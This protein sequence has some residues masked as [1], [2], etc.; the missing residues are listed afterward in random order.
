MFDRRIRTF[1]A[2]G[3]EGITLEGNPLPIGRVEWSPDGQRIAFCSDDYFLRLWNTT[4]QSPGNPFVEG[5]LKHGKTSISWSPD[6]RT[7]ATA[8]SAHDSKLCLWN[9][10]GTTA[11]ILKGHRGVIYQLAWDPRDG[12]LA[13]VG[14]DGTIRVWSAQGQLNGTLHSGESLASVAWKPDGTQLASGCEN[15]TIQLWHPEGR[16]GRLLRGH[17]DCVTCISWSTDGR[18]IAS[19]SRDNTVRLW[20]D[21]GE[22]LFTFHGHASEVQTVGWRPHSHQILSAGR[23]GTVRLWN[24]ETHRLEWMLLLVRDKQTV[25]LDSE[26]KWLGGDPRVFEQEFAY[27]IE[28]P[29]G[30]I[31]VVPPSEF[32]RRTKKTP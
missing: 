5:P 13:S 9:T 24:A 31:E 21:D 1:D 32:E 11:A 3:D 26:G 16:P 14:I 12:R 25:K 15:G 29:T 6:G 19:G 23:D 28:K 2:N 8:E 22:P 4:E 7:I 20:T 27:I 30:A 18:W 17:T 10:D